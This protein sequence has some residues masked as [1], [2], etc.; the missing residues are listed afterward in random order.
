MDIFSDGY[1]QNQIGAITVQLSGCTGTNP[2]FSSM[3]VNG[4]YDGAKEG[5]ITAFT[6]NNC[7]C[8]TCGSHGYDFKDNVGLEAF[9]DPFG[10]W[11][12]M[13]VFLAVVITAPD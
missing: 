8:P 10:E 12:N 9:G 1:C 3:R 11:A 13:L 6:Q 7:G 4:R 2:G 5:T